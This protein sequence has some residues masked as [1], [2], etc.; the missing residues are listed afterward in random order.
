MI[1]TLYL[2]SA[3]READPFALSGGEAREALS[4]R[5]PDAIGLGLTRAIPEQLVPGAAPDFAGAVE[6]WHA[7]PAHAKR[8]AHVGDVA[9]VLAS[10]AEV[11]EVV[12]GHAR[13]VLRLAR[14]H[15]G[16]FIKA[17]LPFR[18]RSGLDARDF[19]RTWWL[20]HGPIAARMQDAVLYR[21]LHPF[22]DGAAAPSTIDGVTEFQWPDVASA[23]AAMASRQMRE[24]QV[25]DAARF[26]DRDSIRTMLAVEEV[27]RAP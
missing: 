15:E 3:D 16:G 2:L 10:D 17:V 25:P 8:A 14:H 9:E 19:Q 21:Q 6:V 24:E 5:F 26:A 27:L 13:T 20:E 23:R 11:A 12:S 1:H 22:V 18:R 7:E 4:T